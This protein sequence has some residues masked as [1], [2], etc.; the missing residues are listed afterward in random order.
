MNEATDENGAGDEPAGS[1]DERVFLA[2]VDETEEMKAAVRYA[3]IRAAR[4]GGRVALLHVVEPPDVQH[5]AA[6]A[7][8][9]REE[10]REESEQ[11]VHSIAAEVNR[12]SGQPALLFLREGDRAEELMKLMDEEPAIANLVLGSHVGSEGPGPL[13]TALMSRLA[14]RL[15]V[16]M[17]LVPGN[18]SW[19]ELD[20]LAGRD[21]PKPGQSD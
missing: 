6:I 3:S 2:V 11:L 19:E 1:P 5:F 10:A 20:R 9:M 14:D 8:I 15:H 13:I 18:L 16:P 7:D 4:T 21:V 17:T 12:I